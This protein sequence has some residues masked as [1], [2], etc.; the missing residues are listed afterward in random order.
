MNQY[1]TQQ[2]DQRPDSFWQLCLLLLL[3]NS[4]AFT[5]WLDYRQLKTSVNS[6]FIAE[7][8]HTTL[9]N[10]G[11]NYRTLLNIKNLTVPKSS[12]GDSEQ[13]WL[14][15]FNVLNLPFSALIDV[16]N[17]HYLALFIL[18]DVKYHLQPTRAPPHQ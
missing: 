7:F 18:D 3:L 17:L 6:D 10:L 16:E 11:D 13:H 12:D 5:G 1:P 14:A 4:Q 2:L 8:N 9:A 15:H